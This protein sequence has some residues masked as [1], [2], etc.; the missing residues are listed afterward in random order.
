MCVFI[1]ETSP[2]FEFKDLLSGRKISTD[3]YRRAHFCSRGSTCFKNYSEEMFQSD[4]EH[5]SVLFIKAY[6]NYPGFYGGKKDVSVQEP[7]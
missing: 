6:N 2:G 7:H 3:T 4:S 1:Y 5:N